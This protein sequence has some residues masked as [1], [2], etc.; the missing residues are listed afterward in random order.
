MDRLMEEEILSYGDEIIPAEGIGPEKVGPD[1]RE[2]DKIIFPE[3]FKNPVYDQARMDRFLEVYGN[4]KN[5]FTVEEGLATRVIRDILKQNPNLTPEDI[6]IESL[7]DGTAPILNQ[8]N[9]KNVDNDDFVSGADLTPEDKAFGNVKRVFSFFARGPSGEKITPGEFGQGMKNRIIP[10]AAGFAAFY[11]GAATTNKLLSGIPPASIPTAA[12]RIGAP[13]IGGLVAS[14][15]SQKPA[16]TANDYI[17]GEG[18]VYLPDQ[19]SNYV[20]GQ[21]FMEGLGWLAAPYLFSGNIGANL[22]TNYYAK[23]KWGYRAGTAVERVMAATRADAKARPIRTLAVETAAA[24]GAGLT[25]GALSETESGFLRFTSEVTGALVGGAGADVLLKQTV[26]ATKFLWS[27]VSKLR[28]KAFRKQFVEQAGTALG[29]RQKAE[30]AAIAWDTLLSVDGDPQEILE[31]LRAFS[32][33]RSAFRQYGSVE[34]PD[35]FSPV[36]LEGNRLFP[37]TF[38]R[39]RFNII[40]KPGEGETAATKARSRLQK[41]GNLTEEYINPE[42]GEMIEDIPTG[43]ASNSVGFQIL[44]NSLGTKSGPGNLSNKADRATA[45]VKDIIKGMIIAGFA[46]QDKDMLGLSVELARQAFAENLDDELADTIQRYDAAFKRLNA[47]SEQTPAAVARAGRDLQN[48]VVKRLKETRINEKRI[49]ANVPEVDIRL[50]SF[51][52]EN[53]VLNTMSLDNGTVVNVPNFVTQW[54]SVLPQDPKDRATFLK[55]PD[56]KDLNDYVNETLTELGFSQSTINSSPNNPFAEKYVK[57]RHEQAGSVRL[58][59]FDN[60]LMS[61]I[62][63]PLEAPRGE[64]SKLSV[65]QDEMSDFSGAGQKSAK[66]YYD[67]VKAYKA[68]LSYDNINPASIVLPQT[69]GSISSRTLSFRRSDLLNKTRM[70]LGG[71]NP[72]TAAGNILGGMAQA[73]LSDLNSY[74]G[75]IAEYHLAR[76]FSKGLNDAFTRPYVGK[77]TGKDRSGASRITPESLISSVFNGGFAAERARAIDALGQ[78]E[79]TQ[80]LTTLLNL[81]PKEV[82]DAR[83]GLAASLSQLPTGDT[84]NSQGMVQGLIDRVAGRSSDEVTAIV[85]EQIAQ[86]RQMN[87][88][89]GSEPGYE[90]FRFSPEYFQALES[91]K[92]LH[93]VQATALGQ[94]L[95][96][97]EAGALLEQIKNRAFDVN[98][99]FIDIPQLRNVLAANK[100]L[101]DRAPELNMNLQGILDQTVNTRSVMETGLRN[102][103]ELS[104]DDAGNFSVPALQK[105]MR[106]A[107]GTGM[108][109]AFPALNDDMQHIIDTKGDWL[110]KVSEQPNLIKQAEEENAWGYYLNTSGS[111]KGRAIEDMSMPFEAILSNT[112][113]LP[114]TRLNDLWRV[115]K[116][117]PD[118][119][120][121]PSGGVVTNKMVKNGFKSSLIGAVLNQ[122]GLMS[123]DKF[124][125]IKAY[126]LF[127]EP[128][129]RSDSKIT[130][131]EW[132]VENKVMPEAEVGRLKKLLNRMAEI[133]VLAASGKGMND[134]EL[135]SKMGTSIELLA[136]ALG[137]ATASK[138]Y[139]TIGGESSGTSSLA[140][141]SRGSSIAI[142][143]ARRI[144]SEMPAVL[145]QTYFQEVLE[146]PDLAIEFLET[147]QTQREADKKAQM[148]VDFALSKGYL[149]LRQPLPYVAPFGSRV[150]AGEYESK[151]PEPLTLK[152]KIDAASLEKDQPVGSAPTRR[153]LEQ[154]R[155]FR[156]ED[157]TSDTQTPPKE[158]ALVKQRKLRDNF[159]NRLRQDAYEATPVVPPTS[160]AQAAPPPNQAASSGPVDRGRY[161]ALFP[162]DMVSG[163]VDPNHRERTFAQGGIVSLMKGR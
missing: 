74:D 128:L 142:N 41:F 96:S 126:E 12:L 72:D 80:Q 100:A 65:L 35:D 104:F 110:K 95:E 125:P 34:F 69:S 113:A 58:D 73:F 155:K 156:G 36:N 154:I 106:S 144:M 127:F 114:T 25:A 122:S 11:T 70:A 71:D 8:F 24:G 9:F 22:V 151:E 88:G 38:D 118:E 119:I 19:K 77:I 21:T 85:D 40:N 149:Y 18:K 130:L 99:G 2:A 159:L 66:A 64:P 136:S 90:S 17:F 54:M 98:T 46:S 10:S 27:G 94:N 32:E 59:R 15:A 5:D 112:Q 120:K 26:P 67:M 115:A 138:L 146:N 134:V 116:N 117:S 109:Q 3:T 141:V 16:Q 133:D 139:K 78:F 23:K 121:L 145:K 76:A 84:V 28:D 79:I 143:H 108:L 105:W 56:Y 52:T 1:R 161:A 37:E 29:S 163:L 44:E 53:D 132:V 48:I 123:K 129:K 57:I 158:D 4:R 39:P 6:S 101:L 43:L 50:G 150:E 51:R 20:S 83:Q 148:I 111:N 135:A 153:S 31:R 103:R 137:S 107:E 33:Q 140:V 14:I 124:S 102:L 160:Q 87:Q 49:W 63:L 162:N 152:Q 131:A 92:N 147:A 97:S 60:L 55:N 91:I 82:D 7:L 13:I 42:T 45:E 68:S 81:S 89:M 62:N 47:G 61:I 93:E 86:A 75:N 157:A 30:M